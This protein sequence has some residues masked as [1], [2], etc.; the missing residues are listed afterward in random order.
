MKKEQESSAGYTSEKVR[1]V[2]SGRLNEFVRGDWSISEI[3]QVSSCKHR[4]ILLFVASGKIRFF[5]PSRANLSTNFLP[6]FKLDAN[7]ASSYFDFEPTS[8]R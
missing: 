8:K 1:R 7:K 3:V 4:V 2:P 6:A 5:L